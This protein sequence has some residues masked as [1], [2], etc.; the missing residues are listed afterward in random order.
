MRTLE[1]FPVLLFDM[2]G[3]IMFG[4][5]RFGEGEDFY[6]TYRAMGG[7][8]L[9]AA[10][11]TRAI[12]RCYEGLRADYENPARYDDF[13]SLREGL[14]R[15]ADTP[16]DELERLELVF[17]LHECGLVPDACAEL[18][19]RLARTHR[20]GLVTNIWAPKYLW[21]REFERTGLYDLFSAMVFSSSF[22]S[23]KPSPKLFREALRGLGVAPEQVLFVGDSLRCDIEG[24]KQLGMHTAWVTDQTRA[25]A[26]VDYLLHDVRDLEQLSA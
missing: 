24:A 14:A 11:V 5:D 17:S 6:G 23:V 8:R 4:H 25:P 9:A 7:R 3:V 26:T 1:R 22:R 18:L 2:H 13:P 19:A 21:E 10:E 12:R 16:S 15:Y 20:I